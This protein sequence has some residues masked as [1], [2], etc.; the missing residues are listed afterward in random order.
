VENLTW[1]DWF[2]HYIGEALGVFLIV[3]FGDAVIFVAV[4]LGV[5]P[6]IVTVGLVWGLAVGM[7]VW[8]AASISGAHF[9]PGVT[10]A[11]ALRRKFPWVHV[12]PYIVFQILGGLLAATVLTVLYNGIMTSK[13]SALGV[14]KGA[15]GSQLISMIYVPYTP[16][17]RMVGIGP[18]SVAAQLHFPDG[19]SLVALWQGALGEFI[20]TALLLVF[21]LVLLERRSTNAPIGWFFPVALGIG[22]LLLVVIE[23]PISMVSLNAARD[24]GPR[25]FLWLTGWGQM[26]FPGPRGDWWVTTIAPTLGAIFGAYFYDFV[27]RRFMPKETKPEVEEEKKPTPIPEKV[28]A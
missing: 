22:V 18:A 5:A 1:R 8:A 2:G 9:N 23:G 15:P 24:L 10:L 4:L 19:W 14:P 17:P 26:A 11:M 7:A 16:N 25:I 13:L 28:S 6:D 27:L 3:F 12:I 20:A 21:I